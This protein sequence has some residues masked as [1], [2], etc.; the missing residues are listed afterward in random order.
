M[1]FLHT[2]QSQNW[3]VRDS[4]LHPVSLILCSSSIHGTA[5]RMLP[6]SSRSPAVSLQML[7]VCLSHWHSRWGGCSPKC[8]ELDRAAALS[9]NLHAERK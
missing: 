1:S 5:E 2:F 3:Q 6:P 4:V 8:P 9:R 7:S